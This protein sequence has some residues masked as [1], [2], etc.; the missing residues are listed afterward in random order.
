M[1]GAANDA[2][3]AVAQRG[4]LWMACVLYKAEAMHWT[5]LAS[6]AP[7]RVA[8][9]LVIVATLLAPARARAEPKDDGYCEYVEGAA[10]ATAAPL[11]AP[12]LFGQF[13][14]V[15]QSASAV[16]PSGD[17]SN[18]RVL[19]GV[20]YSITNIF[21]GLATKSRAHADC[22]RHG[23]LTALTGVTT[24]RALAARIKV[25]EDARTEAE[26][27]LHELEAAVESRQATAQDLVA[28]RLRVE[29]LRTLTANARRELA[30]LPVA[31]ERPVG[32]LI[33]AFRSADAD[34]E[35][36]EGTLRTLRA[37]DVNVRFGADRFLEG[38]NQQ[39]QY[40][41]VVEVGVNL[42]AIWL[43]SANGRAAAGRRR[44]ARTDPQ[45][46]GG[47]GSFDRLRATLEVEGTLVEQTA[48]LVADLE[49]QLKAVAQVSGEDGKRFRETIWFAR[50]KAAADLAYQR[51]HIEAL[52]ELVSEGDRH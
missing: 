35:R 13:G 33:S 39:T 4:S 24:G 28:T 43:G 25:Y 12:Q 9:K 49:R 20:R 40:F 14:Y 47:S 46:L 51:A 8:S 44:Y 29:E 2:A 21:A 3:C 52:R 37:Y 23:V 5:Q 18:L 36:R 42:G 30:A 48:A 50:V 34:L 6:D 15:E 17:S 26:R 1:P 19:A 10:A 32:T 16:T 27:I 41:G 22:Q 7:C 45:Q 38:P 31:D 11:V